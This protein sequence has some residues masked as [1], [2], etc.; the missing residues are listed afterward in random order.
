MTLNF[1]L[2]SGSNGNFYIVY[3]LNNFLK[4]E[5]KMNLNEKLGTDFKNLTVPQKKKY[6]YYN[7]DA[8]I[9]DKLSRKKTNFL[10][11]VLKQTLKNSLLLEFIQIQ[12]CK[13]AR[14]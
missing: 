13:V 9:T 10:P 7:K 5:V 8:K 6:I 11:S 12:I 14:R 1:A 2:T 4:K 3:V